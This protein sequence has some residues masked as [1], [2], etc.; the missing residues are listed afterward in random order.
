MDEFYKWLKY[1]QIQRTDGYSHIGLVDVRKDVHNLSNP[2]YGWHI[3]DRIE[4]LE[5][6]TDVFYWLFRAIF[7]SSRR[8]GHRKVREF[9]QIGK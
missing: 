3:F 7:L 6:L 5:Q 1:I 8:G 2:T 4:L 9:P